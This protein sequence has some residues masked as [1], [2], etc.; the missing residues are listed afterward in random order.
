MTA[1]NWRHQTHVK[2][3]RIFFHVCRYGFSQGLKSFYNTIVY[4][5]NIY[6][7]R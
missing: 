6:F 2:K 3:H 4:M 5:I 7:L 1:A